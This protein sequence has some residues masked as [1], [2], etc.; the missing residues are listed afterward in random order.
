MDSDESN[1]WTLVLFAF[2]L[3]AIISGIFVSGH[4]K[5]AAIERGF[6]EYNATNGNWQ[7]KG[8]K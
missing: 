5:S 2:L 4:F 3:D 7:W 6:A 1:F 8:T